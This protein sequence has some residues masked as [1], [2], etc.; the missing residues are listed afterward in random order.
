MKKIVHMS[1]IHV[2]FKDHDQRF[3]MLAERLIESKQVVAKDCIIVITGDI[4]E[5]ANNPDNSKKAKATIDFLKKNGF[6][7]I[8]LIPGNHDY[9]TGSKG[10]KKFVSIFKQA[11]FEENI[12]F[13]KTDIIDDIAFIGL[14][15]MA[16]EL[17]WYDRLFAEG[18]LGDKQLRVLSQLLEDS[19]VTACRKR[20]IYLHHHPFKF[21]P[22]HQLKDAQKLKN[23]L[24]QAMDRGISIDALLFG[25]NHAG[26]AHNNALGIKRC[27]DA[28]TA[29]LKPRP[30]IFGRSGW[31]AVK[32]SIRLI[33]IESDDTDQDI[34][35]ALQ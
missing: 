23:I 26:D 31:F 24:C 29:T 33:D 13:P 10:D 4:V 22:L 34:V 14:D 20:V 12:K 28:G 5:N 32:A 27:Y 30:K 19:K 21:R 6:N 2:G 15:S 7:D 18:E 35:L 11:Y 1:D 8:L 17:N 9:G 16:D 3:K 25:H